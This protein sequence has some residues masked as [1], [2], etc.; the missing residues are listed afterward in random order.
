MH[1]LPARHPDLVRQRRVVGQHGRRRPR[2]RRRSGRVRARPDG[3][4]HPGGHAGRCRTT[5]W[6][7]RCSRSRTSWAPGTTPPGP[8]AWGR[9]RPSWSSA[10][11]PW[12]CARCSPPSAWAPSGSSRCHGTPTVRPWRGSSAP[13]RSSPSAVRPGSRRSR[14]SRRTSAPTPCSS[15]SAPRSRCSRRSTRPARVDASATSVCRPV[16]PSCRSA[17]CSRRTSRWVVASRPCA[18]TCPSCSPTSSRGASTRH[19]CF[20]ATFALAD[21]ADAYRA[22]DERTAIK[23]L[24]RP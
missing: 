20:D 15:A 2:D 4:R 12:G 17:S 23:T 22:M 14:S 3:G 11:A 5:R 16:G 1:P 10:T 21:V 9:A 13:T 7:R 8:P 19:R 18:R 24:L 6:C